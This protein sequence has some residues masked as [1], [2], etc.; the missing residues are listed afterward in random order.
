MVI[1]AIDD[2]E[3]DDE[4]WLENFDES[5]ESLDSMLTSYLKFGTVID[6]VTS[7]E[8]FDASD[9][10]S[11]ESIVPG[12]LL[13]DYDV[14][15]RGGVLNT[16]AY[17]VAMEQTLET[18]M[19]MA[20][21][22]MGK[23]FKLNLRAGKMLAKQSVKMASIVS[24]LVDSKIINGK[25]NALL[26]SFEGREK[27]TSFNYKDLTGVQQSKLTK[28]IKSYTGIETVGESE[29][30]KVVAAVDSSTSGVEVMSKVYMPKHSNLLI[31]LFYIPASDYKGVVSFFSTMDTDVLPKVDT[32]INEGLLTLNGII[33]KRDWVALSKF[34]I[35]IFGTNAKKPFYTLAH[36]VRASVSPDKPFKTNA[37]KTYASFS[38]LL[39]D[40][41]KGLKNDP[42]YHQNL[43]SSVKDLDVIKDHII[44]I[45]DMMSDMNKHSESRTG[46]LTKEMRR[47]RASK[48]IKE[49]IN[50]GRTINRYSNAAYSRVMEELRDVAVMSGFMAN[51]SKD[52]V[53]AYT[54]VYSRS[55]KLNS[56]TSKF[57]SIVNKIVG[58]K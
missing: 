52:V 16:L 45:S 14:T 17:A 29:V 22:L 5:L 10:A 47:F 18:E 50:N 55:N 6:T 57:I 39:S 26:A 35:E 51:I 15:Q 53:N 56:D 58:S 20:F 38:E 48:T 8:S 33:E 21:F 23:F 49:S 2:V 25:G 11:L 3:D 31:P 9:V 32:G 40:D 44:S 13:D 30:M 27:I 42:K 43:M 7:N 34:D 1:N 4:E 28:V 46:A 19:D 54:T 12:I 41:K 36:S 24:V 37:A